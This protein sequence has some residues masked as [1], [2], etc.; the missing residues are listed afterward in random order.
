MDIIFIVIGMNVS[1]LF[2]FD[3]RI[4]DMKKYFNVLLV[5][6]ILLFL[7]AS[8]LLLY[9]I[10][11]NTAIRALFIPLISQSMYFFM[12]K[13]YYL[14]Y[15]RSSNDTFWTM[16]RSLYTDGWFNA[17]FWIISIVLFMFVL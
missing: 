14:K 4:L 15:E 7:I 3:K 9:N 8:I 17:I 16:D 10:A 12:N 1:I 2:L 11:S 13:W 5:V 6:N